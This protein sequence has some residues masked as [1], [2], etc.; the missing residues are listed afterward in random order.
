M[1]VRVGSTLL[2]CS[3]TF[4]GTGTGG[5]GVDW[6]FILTGRESSRTGTPALIPS[7][8]SGRPPIPLSCSALSVSPIS[9]I[10]R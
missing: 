6:A 10:S 3:G 7:L 4:G 1:G 8:V 2:P 5:V 9:R